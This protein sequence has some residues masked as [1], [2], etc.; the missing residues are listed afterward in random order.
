[1][2]NL[3]SL[4]LNEMF[5]YLSIQEKIRMKQVCRNWKIELDN[6]N[7]TKLCIHLDAYPLNLNWSYTNNLIS[8]SNTFQIKNSININLVIQRFKNLKKLFIFQLTSFD[9]CKE[10]IKR[11]DEFADLIQLEIYDVCFE[12][13]CLNLS[14]LKIISLKYSTFDQIELNT[15]ALDTLICYEKITKIKI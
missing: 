6:Y 8:F 12:A 9:N 3:P 5:S 10:L 15:P 4:V 7:I 13:A 11:L 2:N 14:K 1:M